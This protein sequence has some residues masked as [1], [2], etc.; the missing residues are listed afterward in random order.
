MDVLLP[1]RLVLPRVLVTTTQHPTL[2]AFLNAFDA[3]DQHPCNSCPVCKAGRTCIEL[4]ELTDEMFK[5]RDDL[6]ALS[7]GK[8]NA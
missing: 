7:N 5:T 3:W 6:K 8:G 1:Q 2:T 4:E